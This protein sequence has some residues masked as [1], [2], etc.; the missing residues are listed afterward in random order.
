MV[1]KS[2]HQV[3]DRQSYYNLFSIFSLSLPSWGPLTSQYRA[4]SGGSIVFV[5]EQ[6][7]YPTDCL[8]ESMQSFDVSLVNWC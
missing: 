3:L 5:L 7:S 1:D 4:F 6:L 8:L 2:I